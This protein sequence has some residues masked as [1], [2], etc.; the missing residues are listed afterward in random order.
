M[1]KTI[2]FLATCMTTIISF[3]QITT[4]TI[5]GV[6]VNEKKEVLVGASVTATHVPTGTTYKTVTN[7]TGSY[8]FPAVRVGGP[9]TV[10]VSF[11][12]YKNDQVTDIGT[13]L[14]IAS[15]VDFT[16]FSTGSSL[17]EVVVSTNRNGIFSKERTG[18]AQQFGRRELQNIPITGA[19]TI[20][21]IT[22]Y[23]SNGNG[24][25]F[26]GQDS[27]LN[28]FTI[29]GSQFNNGFGLGSSAQAGGRTGASAISLDAIEQLQLNIAPFDI[30]QSGF[31][32]AGINAVTR[33]GTNEIEGSYYQTERDNTSRYNGDKAAGVKVTPSKF[34]EKV[35]GFR[36][37]APIIKNKLFIFANYE[38]LEK[39]EPGTNWISTGS[40]LTG[41]Q[42]SRPTYAQLE[43]LSNFMRDKFNYITGPWENYNNATVSEK[44]LIRTDWNIND[45]HKLTARY[46]HH[47]SNADINISNS[48]SAGFGNRTNSALAMSF[49]NSGYGIMDNTRS[50]VV[51]LNSKISNT[52]HNNLIIGYDKQ[53]ED[54]SYRS[55]MFPT[56]DIKLGSTTLTSV[57]FDPFTPGNKLDYN[58]FHVTNNI[59]KYADKHTLVAGFNFEKYQSNNLFFP[60]SN[61]VYVFNSLEDFYT[62][63]NQS[64][65]AG[66]APSAFVP[67]R[68]QFRYSA[69][70]GAIEPLQVLNTSRLDV[71]AQDEY[72]YNRDLK[73]TAGIRVAMIDF[74]NTA[75]EN[76][77]IT[78]M[79]FA[80]G[81]SFNTG[82]MPK[83]QFL[84]E[85]RFGFNWDVEGKKKTQV[86]GGTGIFTGRPPYVFISNQIGNNGVLTGFIDVSGAAAAK[87]GF[88][89][90][91]NKYFIPSTPTLPSTFD[92]ALTEENYKF[93]QVFKSN[94]AIDQKLP[95]GLVGTIEFLYNKNLN[96]VHYYNDNLEN[97]ISSFTGVD[98]R[99]RFAGN[100]NG[101]RINDNVSNAIVLANKNS[102][103]FKSMTLKLEMPYRK[104]VWGSLAWTTSNATDFMSAG[105]IASGSWTSA[106]A[107]NGNNN[108]YLSN[109]DFNIPNRIVGLFG[110]RLEYGGEFG[111]ATSISVGYVGSQA[112]PYSYTISGDMNG[113]RVNNNELIFI[114][115][116]GT[117]IKFAPLTVGSTTYSEANQQGALEKYIQQ[118]KYLNA[119]RGK[120]AER[121][122]ST[123]PMLHRFDVSVVQEFYVK[124]KGKRN[125]L[126]LRADILNF[127]NMIN[128]DWGVSQRVTNPQILAFSSVNS[129]GEP[130]YRLATQTENGNTSLIKTTYQKNSSVFDIWQAQLG[131]RYIFGR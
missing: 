94:L 18:T 115:L 85:P 75:I 23:N 36:I 38:K 35:Q 65:A 84:Y 71:Y 97:P 72:Q 73:F 107:V 77:A 103:D 10:A 89:P 68:T 37:G 61:G 21:G 118:D 55:S 67:A 91:P 99:F 25:S 16:L 11:V 87:Y 14:G 117:D 33:S 81:A 126:Q 111:G 59:T 112:N 19:R 102:G 63:A 46:V 82:V 131:L 50:I 4:S 100:D 12:G 30:R 48:A 76:P 53:I 69:L 62:A 114:P 44:F 88:T 78:A 119:N 92:I 106:R 130:L 9:F 43:T 31:T 42:I 66:G 80:N 93:P 90:N 127:G 79:S 52:L 64:L 54:R 8:V 98:N 45:Q 83:T 22:K 3:A 6:V 70:P 123:I 105:S 41:S 5:S 86:R 39:T 110:Y 57:G 120:Y 109:S 116:K 58:T 13:N 7:K 27:R 24:A 60:A 15:N 125:T 51:E 17:Q 129:A 113:D 49:Q 47:N 29:D 128:D 26:G 40:P 95:F 1:K 2:L 56:I 108:L 121:N 104:G 122:A 34:S 28:N 101:V 96:A 74:V 20:E 32:G 124:V